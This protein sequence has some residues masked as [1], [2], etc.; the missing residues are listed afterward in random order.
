MRVRLGVGRS[1]GEARVASEE[2][3][4]EAECVGRRVCA[5]WR[6][7]ALRTDSMKMVVAVAA[8]YGG[9]VSARASSI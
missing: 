8:V 4:R 5:L 7:L 6:A 9:V 2:V 3:E 1:V